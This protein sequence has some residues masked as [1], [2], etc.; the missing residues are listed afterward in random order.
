MAGRGL[1]YAP[2]HH[3][4]TCNQPGTQPSHPPPYPPP[5]VVPSPLPLSSQKQLLR[6]LFLRYC[7]WCNHTNF[8]FM[9]RSQWLRCARDAGLTSSHMNTPELSLIYD[10]VWQQQQ[11][12]AGC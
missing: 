5:L 8:M 10:K 3:T 6:T 1:H 2:Y 9:D 12:N 11:G 7:A 4:D